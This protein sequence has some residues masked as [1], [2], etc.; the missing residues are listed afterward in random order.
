MGCF[1]PCGIQFVTGA[2]VPVGM[3][4]KWVL[5]IK[6]NRRQMAFTND[7][8]DGQPINFMVGCLDGEYTYTAYIL[9]PASEQMIFTIEGTKY[10]CFQFTTKTEGLPGI[11]A[12]AT[13][14]E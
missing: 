2:N 10:D 14:V 9:N 11:N 5:F 4:G 1:E 6:F 3:A 13:A 12:G 7:L 8:V